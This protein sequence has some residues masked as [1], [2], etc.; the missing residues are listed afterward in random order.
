MQLT[1]TELQEK[2]DKLTKDFTLPIERKDLSKPDN[3]RWLS[4][5]MRMLN[6]DFPEYMQAKDIVDKMLNAHENALRLM[7]K[8]VSNPFEIKSAPSG[9]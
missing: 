9:C 2:F 1:F 3:L 8:E 7:E 6:G 5:Y 4:S